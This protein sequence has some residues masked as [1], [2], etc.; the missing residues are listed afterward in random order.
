MGGAVW[1]G[2]RLR[3]VLGKAGVEATAVE[4]WLDGADGPV[5]QQTPDFRKSLPMEKALADEVI[6]AYAMNG[7]KLPLLNGFP[8]V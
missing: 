3:D 1:R 8:R 4:V 7:E 5:L 6:I 2:A